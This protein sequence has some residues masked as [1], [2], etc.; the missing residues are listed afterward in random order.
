M[1]NK[2]HEGYYDPTA[3]KA[4]QR[5][6]RKKFHKIDNSKSLSYQLGKLY[7]FHLAVKNMKQQKEGF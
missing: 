3:S 5:A 1:K 4:I 7:C 6:E 2:N